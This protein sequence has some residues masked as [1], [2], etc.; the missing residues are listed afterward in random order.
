MVASYHTKLRSEVVLFDGRA[1][2]LSSPLFTI[3]TGA[4]HM[5]GWPTSTNIRVLHLP[6]SEELCLGDSWG[7]RPIPGIGQSSGNCNCLIAYQR[8]WPL[9]V[10]QIFPLFL[11]STTDNQ[12]IP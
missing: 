4:A 8:E 7:K 10:T 1:T 2:C 5:G 9:V 12:V 11:G 3:L 6:R